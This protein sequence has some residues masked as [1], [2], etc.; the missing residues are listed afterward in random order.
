M[1]VVFRAYH[2]IKRVNVKP[3][4]IDCDDNLQAI[5]IGQDWKQADDLVRDEVYSYEE[6][7][8]FLHLSYGYYNRFRNELAKLAGYPEAEKS[9]DEYTNKYPFAQSA[10]KAESGLLWDLINFSDC[11]GEIGAKTCQKILD[12]LNVL[13]PR[14]FELPQE[15]QGYFKDLIEGFA[16]VN[17]DGFIQLS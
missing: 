6:Q 5:Y 10:F 14:I 12:D 2:G 16:F 9:D 8:D 17:G 11:E 7:W 4:D 3:D 15:F 13:R 1:S